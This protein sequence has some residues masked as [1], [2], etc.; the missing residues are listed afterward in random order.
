MEEIAAMNYFLVATFVWSW[1]A[2]VTAAPN[3]VVFIADDHGY[4]DSEVYGAKDV[5]TPNMV[6][7]AQSGMTF[8]HCFVASPSCAP[9]R[10]AMLTGLM[11]ARNGAE[12]NH[13]KPRAEL[14]KLPAYL[15]E[16]G[17]EVA[18]FGKVAHY[19][20]DKDYGFDHYDKEHA[21]TVVREFLERRNKSKP[22]CL[23]VGAHAPHVPWTTNAA[24]SIDSVQL[25]V[26]HLDTPETRVFR[27]RY[28]TD[29]TKADAE[30]GEIYE[31]G[32]QHL[33]TNV[34]YIF[35]SD[36]GAQWPFGKWN[37]YDAGIRV[38][39]IAAWPG[40][41]APGS[42]SAA[43]VSW[44]DILP[45]LIEV[46]GGTPPANIDGRSFA[47]VLRGGARPHRDR[48]FS[49]HSADGRMNVYPI[50]AVR[51]RD[52]K[53]ILNLHPEFK[54]TTHID[55]AQDRDGVKY[56]RSWQAV[57]ATNSPAAQV[58]KRYQE[59][60]RE[61]LYDLEND[62]FEQHNLAAEGAHSKRLREFR[63]ELNNWMEVQGDKRTVFE[64]P[65]LLDKTP[66]SGQESGL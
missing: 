42:R 49:T 8:T 22:L 20:H 54:Y 34:L 50:R 6:R 63:A 36:H 16:I 61:E 28:Y 27:S 29:V 9:S 35:T 30:F 64:Q 3:M 31:L 60:P 17:Y 25:P 26:T 11:P 46:G 18:G 47:P 19:N 10:A 43:M 14:K 41:V 13:A 55:A 66:R 62:P 23:F 5:R 58:V 53:Y 32:R 40:V 56:W 38:A 52:W 51:T 48:I 37:L 4:L 15:Q 44:V 24:Y 2:V 33:G 65:R 21:P 57:A 7:L 1:W 45:T 59:R 39:F 12:A